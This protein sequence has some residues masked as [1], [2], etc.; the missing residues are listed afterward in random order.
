MLLPAPERPR[1][2]FPRVLEDEALPELAGVA[3]AVDM[4]LVVAPLLFRGGGTTSRA[5]L[6]IAVAR[7]ADDSPDVDAPVVDTDELPSDRMLIRCWA[8]ASR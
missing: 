8:C 1:R 3:V 4:L 6:T 2:D 5:A 7:A